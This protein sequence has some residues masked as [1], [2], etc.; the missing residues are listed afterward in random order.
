M[1]SSSS[2]NWKFDFEEV[3]NFVGRGWNVQRAKQIIYQFPREIVS[4]DYN[5]FE[6][7]LGGLTTT[8]T[9]RMGVSIDRNRLS[10]DTIDLSIPVIIIELDGGN[11]MLIDGWH[12]LGKAIQLK[13]NL[14]A[15]ILSIKESKE[16][17]L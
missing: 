10:L 5:A 2:I 9:Y 4:I 1:D 12:R 17:S 16:I 15:V 3:F 8:G 6:P 11:H 13:Q 7:L 14:R